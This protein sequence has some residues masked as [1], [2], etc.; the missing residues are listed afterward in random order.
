VL[1]RWCVQR[2]AIVIPKSVRRERIAENA[3]IFDFALSEQE[4]SAL[5]HLDRTG[6]TDLARERAW[7]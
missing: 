5:D 6:G 4:M 7:W 3:Q 1:L 2:D